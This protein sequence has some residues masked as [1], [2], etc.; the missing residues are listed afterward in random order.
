M[1][2]KKYLTSSIKQ[3][4]LKLYKS[5]HLWFILEFYSSKHSIPLAPSIH[6]TLAPSASPRSVL[7]LPLLLAARCFRRPFS[8]QSAPAHWDHAEAW[9]RHPI[10]SSWITKTNRPAEISRKRIQLVGGWATHLKNIGQIGSFPQVGEKKVYWKPP[11]SQWWGAMNPKKVWC[12][13][14]IYFVIYQYV[15]EANFTDGLLGEFGSPRIFPRWKITP[16]LIEHISCAY[17]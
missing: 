12:L 6:S 10:E 13:I 14:L 8:P 2:R 5:L 11:P 1:Y 3:I 4:R 17:V 16:N 9:Q 15:E 7:S